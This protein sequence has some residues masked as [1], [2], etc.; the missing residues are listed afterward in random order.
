MK[1]FGGSSQIFMHREM[2]QGQHR[3]FEKSEGGSF[4]E[5]VCWGW[6]RGD[7]EQIYPRCEGNGKKAEG[8]ICELFMNNLSY[9]LLVLLNPLGF[10]RGWRR[11]VP[12]KT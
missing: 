8:M 5:E 10:N 4:F 11:L 1:K 6:G 3:F 9:R 2:Q 7:L 12:I